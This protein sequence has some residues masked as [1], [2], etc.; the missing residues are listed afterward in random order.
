MT[1][2]TMAFANSVGS[3]LRVART[4]RG[5]SLSEVAVAA[6]I[7]TATLS[8]IETEKQSL[9]VGLLITISRVL[10][11]SPANVVGGEDGNRGSEEALVNALAALPLD[12]RARVIAAAS[13]RRNGRRSA[14]DL[15]S[16]LGSL[17]AT[18]DLLREELV[19]VQRNARRRR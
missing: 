13:K 19:E 11:V 8:R 9:D 4:A 15:Q 18:M 5:M 12:Q 3:T 7:S 10:Q 17:L 6:G 16:Q 1:T 2:T 14:D